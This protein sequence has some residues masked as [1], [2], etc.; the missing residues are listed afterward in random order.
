MQKF[1]LLKDSSEL[2]TLVKPFG[3]HF[4]TLS[5]FAKSPPAIHHQD[6]TVYEVYVLPRKSA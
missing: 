6:A 4:G 3:P 1:I 2:I 5:P